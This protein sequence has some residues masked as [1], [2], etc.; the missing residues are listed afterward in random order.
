[1]RIRVQVRSQ[2]KSH[3]A[4]DFLHYAVC[5]S[6]VSPQ[7][8][9][10]FFFFFNLPNRTKLHAFTGFPEME[11]ALENPPPP[12]VATSG[13]GSL[14]ALL[15]HTHNPVRGPPVPLWEKKGK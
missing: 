7:H 9:R 11:L 2:N 5:W 4:G 1:M 15:P 13:Q 6:L 3:L 14:S 8:G 12:P 10:H